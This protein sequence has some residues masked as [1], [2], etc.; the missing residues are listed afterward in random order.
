MILSTG[1]SGSWSEADMT[2]PWDVLHWAQ[3]CPPFYSLLLSSTSLH[4]PSIHYFDE[5]YWKE[6]WCGALLCDICGSVE[7]SRVWSGVY[8][9]GQ[10]RSVWRG[11]T[12][13]N[14][15]LNLIKP[16]LR[17]HNVIA[18][19]CNI[20]QHDVATTAGRLTKHNETGWCCVC[21]FVEILGSKYFGLQCR[22]KK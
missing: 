7:Q 5:T 9:E 4:Q 21:C 16:G 10:L 11:T 2:R 19:L 6:G 1:G 14:I 20:L 12:S 3:R 15:T 17:S 8:W 18:A 22:R 13:R